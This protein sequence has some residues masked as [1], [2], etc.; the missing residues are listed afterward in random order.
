MLLILGTRLIYFAGL[1]DFYDDR[2]NTLYILSMPLAHKKSNIVFIMPYHVEPLERLEKMLT[3]KQLDT[4]MGK[5]QKTAVALS[6]P[7]VSMEVSHNLQVKDARKQE[8]LSGQMTVLFLSLCLQFTPFFLS[9]SLETPLGPGS[10]RG[11][12]QIQS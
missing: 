12:G 2:S 1:F 7:K 5:L 11:C 9:V 10:D 4:W 6:L 8:L 3:K